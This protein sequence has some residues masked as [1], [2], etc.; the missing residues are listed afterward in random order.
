VSRS[1]GD[2]AVV[3]PVPETKGAHTVALTHGELVE[4]EGRSAG[5]LLPLGQSDVVMECL[6]MSERSGMTCGLLA[7]V[8]VGSTLLVPEFDPV[9]DPA[10]ALEMIAAERITVLEGA[11]ALYEALLDAAHHYDEDFSSL[12]VC[13]SAGGSLPVD[14]LRRFQDRFGC[15]VVDADELSALSPR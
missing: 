4:R 9:F 5:L 12:R 2:V 13:V 8:A 3:L 1:A 6:P 14:V 11:P 15:I 7:P 10:T